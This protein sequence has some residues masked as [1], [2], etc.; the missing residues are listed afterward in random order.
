MQKTKKILSVLRRYYN[1][2]EGTVH[3][4]NPFLV[5]VSCVLSQRTREENTEKAA[6][7]LFA[8]A[9]TPQQIAKL[10]LKKLQRLIK[11]AG[12]YR[13]KALRLKQISKIL[14]KEYNGKVPVTRD[15]LM[16]LPGVGFKTADV[17][18]AYG[19]DIPAIPV[20]THVF[21]CSKRLG[22]V[23]ADADVEEVR[24]HLQK[25][26][27][28]RLW[29]IVNLGFVNFGREVCKQK[30]RCE[31]CELRNFCRYYKNLRKKKN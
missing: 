10:P 19:H 4:K 12:F 31:I 28:K 9:K 18:L 8:K 17:V 23:S 5:L 15:E 11:P 24:K 22:L 16:S 27:P 2:R 20:D 14:L 30:P 21:R 1:K 25:I 13:Q 29:H 3:F 26:F 7:Q 6:K